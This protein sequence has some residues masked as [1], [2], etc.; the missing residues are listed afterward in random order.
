MRTPTAPGHVDPGLDGD[1]H[2]RRQRGVALLGQPRPLV[3]VEP[4]PVAQ[5]VAE[6]LGVAGGVDDRAGDGVDLAPGG[7]GAHG[8]QRRLL[9]L[10]DELVDLAV[11]RVEVTRRVGAR[12][13][14]GVAV[15]LRAPVDDDQRARRDLAPRAAWRAGA[16][17]ARPRRRSAGRRRPAP[18]CGACV[19]SRSSATSR[20][21]RPTSP[22]PRTSVSASSASRAAARMRLEL[23]GVLDRA[24]RPRS[25][26]PRA[27]ARSRRAACRSA[28]RG[29]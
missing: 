17:R 3:D 25:R 26:R 21:V 12:A 23:V 1:D 16:P 8:R 29:P 13:V 5:P 6:V 2:A 9:S 10:E 14:G 20:S 22:R 18:P 4:D 19:N 27:R 28:A 11:A 7:A 24:Q 15:E